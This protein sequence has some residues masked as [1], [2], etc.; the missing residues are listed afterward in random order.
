VPTFAMHS[1][2]EMAGTGDAWDL[3]RVLQRFYNHR[4]RLSAA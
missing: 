1:I 4:G 2:R 3:C